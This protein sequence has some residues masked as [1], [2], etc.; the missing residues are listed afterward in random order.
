MHHANVVD[1]PNDAFWLAQCYY[2]SGHYARA[3]NLLA[4]QALLNASV[5]CRCLASQCLVSKVSRPAAFDR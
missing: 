5:A 4:K 2:D 1:D 3:R